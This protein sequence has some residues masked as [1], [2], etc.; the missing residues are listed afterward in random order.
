MTVRKGTDVSGKYEETKSK[1]QEE[2][3]LGKDFCLHWRSRRAPGSPR[4]KLN[5]GEAL[6]HSLWV[7][8]DLSSALPCWW[9][10]MEPE[11]CQHCQQHLE[12]PWALRSLLVHS[13]ETPSPP[14][15]QQPPE[16]DVGMCMSHE[17]MITPQH[18]RHSACQIGNKEG[19]EEKSGKRRAVPS[20]N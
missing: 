5:T 13:G 10:G 12:M 9:V 18:R 2:T 1:F 16:D 19:S 15:T 20:S 4:V 7:C 6:A 14:R 8:R 3:Q 11:G 17:G